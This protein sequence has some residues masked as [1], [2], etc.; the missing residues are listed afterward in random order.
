MRRL[1]IAGLAAALVV[2]VAAPSLLVWRDASTERSAI[3]D[4]QQTI[5]KL[6]AEVDV[7]E[8]HAGTQADWVLIAARAETSVVT[9]ETGAGLGSGWVARSGASGSDLIT[10]FHVVA[11][12]W[13]GGTSQVDV[14]QKDKT[15]AGTIVRVDR[16]DD[17]ALVHVSER[18]PAL[19]VAPA[20]PSLGATVM[21]V[22]SPLGLDGTV[23]VGVV[24]GFRSLEGSDYLQFSAPIS[25]GNSGGPVLDAHGDVV[26]VASAKLVGDGVEALSLGIPVQVACTGLGECPG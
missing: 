14:R 25:P 16:Q 7:L 24:S 4:Q 17:L 10:N 11:D 20:R 21:T 5:A 8:A 13:N 18:L 6:K 19:T 12:A 26:A 2:G 15:L 3:T 22:G 1:R 9:I 23:S